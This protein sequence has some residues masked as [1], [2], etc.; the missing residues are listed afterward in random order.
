[1]KAPWLSSLALD[2]YTGLT[3]RKKSTSRRVQFIPKISRVME[4]WLAALR[5]WGSSEDEIRLRR[6][7]GGIS[8]VI[9]RTG[10][11]T[12]AGKCCSVV[13]TIHDIEDRRRAEDDLRRQKEILPKLLTTFLP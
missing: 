11:G 9:R 7:D 4:K 1:M 12:T 6:S 5:L 8:L 10:R 13:R 2:A 3:L